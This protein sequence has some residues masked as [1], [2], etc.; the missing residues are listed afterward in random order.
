[1]NLST[2]QP[3]NKK[4][5][6]LFGYFVVRLFGSSVNR[7]SGYIA[8]SSILVIAAIVLI[9]GTTVALT[10]ITESQISLAGI[11][12]DRALDAAEGCAEETLLYL[13]ENNLLP[14][15]FTIPI[16]TTTVNCTITEISHVGS[17]WTF[18][19]LVTL[20]NHTKSVR[21]TLTRSSTIDVTRWEEI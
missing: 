11:Q 16:G 5:N 14:A 7:S 13:N 18:T 8:I 19:A 12:N 17:N 1:M 9:I 20:N 6:R 2:H 10:S 21:V 15:P 3:I 4:V